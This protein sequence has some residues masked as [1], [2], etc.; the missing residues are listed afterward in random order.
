MARRHAR[1][2]YTTSDVI[3]WQM[4][5]AMTGCSSC[6]RTSPIWVWLDNAA[7][8]RR[9]AADSLVC[10]FWQRPDYIRSARSNVARARSW[11]M[12][13]SA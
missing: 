1:Q 12:E 10:S 6:A 8:Q 3:D 11:R 5:Q 9:H 4:R 2:G 13:I 7:K